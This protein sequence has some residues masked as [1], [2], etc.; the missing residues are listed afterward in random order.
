M[1]VLVRFEV[2]LR[3][4]CSVAQVMFESDGWCSAERPRSV[5]PAASDPSL[6]I[7]SRAQKTGVHK[8]I[9]D[10]HAIVLPPVY[11]VEIK[12]CERWAFVAE[13][14]SCDGDGDGFGRYDPVRKSRRTPT[15][16]VRCVLVVPILE[17]HSML[18][19]TVNVQSTLQ[20]GCP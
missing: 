3:G 6:H 7:D 1:L 11:L 13:P 19:N 16:F 15:V 20:K 4:V 8:H 12:G 17:L 9:R 5:V 2:W 14:T 18:D 10:V